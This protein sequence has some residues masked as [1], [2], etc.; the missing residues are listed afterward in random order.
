[1]YIMNTILKEEIWSIW[2]EYKKLN[3]VDDKK[4][5]DCLVNLI[6]TLKKNSL[7]DYFAK[8][9]CEKYLDIDYNINIRHVL[10]VEI[11]YPYLLKSLSRVRMPEVRYLAQLGWDTSTRMKIIEILNL[12]KEVNLY[13]VLLN[14]AYEKN[15]RD[16]KTFTLL[17]THHFETLWY[18]KGS[19]P[20][21]LNLNLKLIKKSLDRLED[22]LTNINTD[23]LNKKVFLN[24]FYH[25]KLYDTWESYIKSNSKIKFD[26]WLKKEGIELHI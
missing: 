19:L 15:P 11:L 9:F 13:E 10:K 12:D 5:Y 1:M 26:K 14:I 3:R 2:N 7:E 22:L 17:L 24:Y 23:Y 4:S 25:K 6:N 20:Q 8:E 16:E 21:R 18:A